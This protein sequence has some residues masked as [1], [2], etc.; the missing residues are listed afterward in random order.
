MSADVREAGSAL[1]VSDV[2]GLMRYANLHLLYYYYYDD[3]YY[4]YYY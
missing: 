2:F 3:Y 1:E 4:Y